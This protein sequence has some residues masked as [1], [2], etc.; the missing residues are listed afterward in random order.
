MELNKSECYHYSVNN[1]QNKLGV[2]ME[3][4]QS[5]VSYCQYL[6]C[7]QCVPCEQHKDDKRLFEQ[8]PND[9]SFAIFECL[10]AK[11]LMATVNICKAWEE[12]QELRMRR[13]VVEAS[14]FRMVQYATRMVH[15]NNQLIAH[16]NGVGNQMELTSMRLI[17]AIQR[18]N[19]ELLA[20]EL[21]L[22]QRALT[23]LQMISTV[24][25]ATLIFLV[26]Y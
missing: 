19:N 3:N 11:S 10:D 15:M 12:N 14:R 7:W 21:A 9:V 17:V 4:V 22:Q 8:L 6:E 13:G 1:Y 26:L 20:N 2:N 23:R 5:K 24:A 25:I 16:L 18:G